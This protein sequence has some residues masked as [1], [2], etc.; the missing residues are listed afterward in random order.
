MF[1][2]T[3]LG[4]GERSESGVKVLNTRHCDADTNQ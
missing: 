1:S 2:A 4:K 3:K